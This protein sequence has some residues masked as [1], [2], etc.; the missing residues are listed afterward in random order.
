MTRQLA[1]ELRLVYSRG[2]TRENKKSRLFSFFP[3]LL[4]TV[5]AHTVFIVD[6]FRSKSDYLGDRKRKEPHKELLVLLQRG[7]KIE[8][9]STL[10]AAVSRFKSTD[11]LMIQAPPNV[12]TSENGKD[13]GF[14]I[15]NQRHLFFSV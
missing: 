5:R 2:E 7:V 4:L 1:T 6:P 11:A 12:A 8:V 10:D 9:V 14:F 3:R 13:P 15:L